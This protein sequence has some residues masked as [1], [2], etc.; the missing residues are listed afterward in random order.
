MD[1]FK[2]LIKKFKKGVNFWETGRRNILY[3]KKKNKNPTSLTEKGFF[4]IISK[5]EKNGKVRK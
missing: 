1:N 5:F 2:V 4:S 3:L